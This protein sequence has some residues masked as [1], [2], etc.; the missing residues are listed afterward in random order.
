MKL[1]L[2]KVKSAPQNNAWTPGLH[3]Y[4]N[5]VKLVAQSVNDWPGNKVTVSA[6]D[7]G[8][9]CVVSLQIYD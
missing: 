3:P 2:F 4:Q 1:T 5:E 6:L 8:Q 7:F 9:F